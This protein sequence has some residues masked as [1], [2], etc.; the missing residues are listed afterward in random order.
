MIDSTYYLSGDEP[1]TPEPKQKQDHWDETKV[2]G[3]KRPRIDAY[4]RLSG[5]ATSVPGW[6]S[7][8]VNTALVGDRSLGASPSEAAS[9]CEHS[10]FRRPTS[11]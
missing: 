4:E 10:S 7:F 2:V 11:S 6:V 9:I 1:T 5:A 8:P 3:G